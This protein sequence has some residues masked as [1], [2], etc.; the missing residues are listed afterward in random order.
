MDYIADNYLSPKGITSKKADAFYAIYQQ[1]GLLWELLGSQCKH[2]D[3]YR[4]QDHKLLCKICGKMKEAKESYYLLPATGEKVIGR[5]VKPRE[6]KFRRISKKQAEILNDTIKFHGA[7]LHVS[8]FNGYTDK[9]DKIG[10]EI[11][12]A[13]DR[14]VIL[15]ED[16]LIFEAS[17]Y[18]ASMRIE[19]VK[20]QK[21]IY[22]GFVWELPK[23]ILKR[24]PIILSC[25]RY[26]KLVEI[27]LLK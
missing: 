17:K 6:D 11:N 2:R 20:K 10:K 7:R 14:M 3:G 13:A 22:G 19:S 5:M 16:R 25:D 26:G 8:V 9:W 18:I 27:E 15:K 4:K 1:L 12:V 24:M 21:P 23:R